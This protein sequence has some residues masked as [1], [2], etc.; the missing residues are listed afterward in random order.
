MSAYDVL[1]DLAA[2]LCVQIEQDGSPE[3]CFC[4]VVPGEQISADYM[5]DCTTKNG[6]A[7]VRLVNSYPSVTPG[8][9]DDTANGCGSLLGL[10]IEM[11]V[12]R[13]MPTGLRGEPPTPE[14]KT[15]ATALQMQDMTTM[16]RAIKCCS[17]LK[18]RD[19]VLGVYQ[20]AGPAGLAV[21]GTWNLAVI[22]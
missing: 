15:A 7:W 4:G 2:C 18:K 12:L 17:S 19:Y 21:G 5:G 3:P 8:T 6:A 13:L 20:P 1:V 9:L 10:D 14:Q 22:L 16:R 11:G